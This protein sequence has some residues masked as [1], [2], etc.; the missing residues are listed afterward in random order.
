M[1]MPAIGAPLSDLVVL[2][3]TNTTCKESNSIR[4]HEAVNVQIIRSPTWPAQN[5]VPMTI[6]SSS[7]P[8]HQLITT[9]DQDFHPPNATTSAV[10]VL[11]V[12]RHPQYPS[13][14]P[15]RREHV[16]GDTGEGRPC[17]TWNNPR[18]A[19]PIELAAN[20][21]RGKYLLRGLRYMERRYRVNVPG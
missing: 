3:S 10:N 12:V 7:C 14:S 9:Y 20:V 8:V 11:T 2:T 21:P 6:K 17:N 15:W 16:A 1:A 18:R 19:V 13:P 5:D 4:I